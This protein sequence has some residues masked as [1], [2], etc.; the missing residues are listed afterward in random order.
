MYPVLVHTSACF[1]KLTPRAYSQVYVIPSCTSDTGG[2]G[3]RQGNTRSATNKNLRQQYPVSM[4]LV[5]KDRRL[6][7][8]SYIISNS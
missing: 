2:G 4:L 8:F 3:G 5:L 6:A 7:D 1:D